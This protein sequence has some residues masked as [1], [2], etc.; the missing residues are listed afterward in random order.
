MTLTQ[1]PPESIE[2][3]AA[4][5]NSK[6]SP[7]QELVD[8]GF[9]NGKNTFLFSVTTDSKLRG[10]VE[11]QQVATFEEASALPGVFCFQKILLKSGEVPV[12]M[13]RKAYVPTSD[14]SVSDL[15]VKQA[16]VEAEWFRGKKE[17]DNDASERVRTY[18]VEGTE[19][20]GISGKNTKQPWSAAFISY[21]VIKSGGGN[22]FKGSTAHWKYINRA[23][24]AKLKPQDDPE[25][26]F[27]G[28]AVNAYKP[29]VGD[30]IAAWRDDPDTTAVEKTTF[31]EVVAGKDG[32]PS[33]CDIVV[34]HNGSTIKTIGGNVNNDVSEKTFKLT[35]QGYVD[36]TDPKQVQ[37]I[38]I[39]ENRMDAPLAP[40]LAGGAAPAPAA[41][42]LN[43]VRIT[44][45]QIRTLAPN[46]KA[47]YLQAFVNADAVLAP[48]QI[49]ASKLRLRHFMAQVLHESG[50]L[51]VQE[52]DMGYSVQGMMK[53]W[54]DRFPTEASAKP[55]EYK[56]E[57]LAN[58]V[59]SNRMGNGDE[60]SGDGWRYRGRG[61]M[62]VTGR[63]DYRKYGALV[64]ANLE[65]DPDLAFAAAYTLKIAAEEWKSK[66]CNALA[67]A[68]NITGITQKINGGQTGIAK[69]KAWYEK[70]L[71]VWA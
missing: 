48:Y 71:T 3:L 18:W 58:H 4:F 56:P 29:Q 40:A 20:Q 11:A 57:K 16:I 2:Q 60:A 67:D 35:P 66:G 62:Q 44:M 41:A 6:E 51:R 54:K 19:T 52:E 7:T 22:R 8:M 39:L 50:G 17:T 30:L 26:G 23:V 14:T 21:L 55:Y 5:V 9:E 68:D 37:V 46:A 65:A 64:G 25:Y 45:D 59:Y 69:R 27:W 70:T 47:E 43:V 15:M 28:H 10:A 31:E 38:A 32:Y 12:A 24:K 13:L 61:L 36:I 1:D 53:T 49:N 42:P 33:H 34:A 63:E